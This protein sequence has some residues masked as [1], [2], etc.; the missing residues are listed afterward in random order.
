MKITPV[1]Y[2]PKK[3]KPYTKIDVVLEEFAKMDAKVVELDWKGE[4]Y[5][6]VNSLSSSFR[7]AID[8]LGYNMS[9]VTRD[10]HAYLIKNDLG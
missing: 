7:R 9:Y 1:D 3:V 4:G 2:A 8:R 6:T 5:K 10:N